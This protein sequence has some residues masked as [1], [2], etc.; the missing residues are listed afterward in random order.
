MIPAPGTTPPPF[1]RHAA[2]TAF[3]WWYLLL[4]FPCLF[5]VTMW[6]MFAL[7]IMI[8]KDPPKATSS[9]KP[10]ALDHLCESDTIEEC[11]ADEHGAWGFA[12][13]HPSS[14]AG[15]DPSITVAR[16]T[17]DGKVVSATFPVE[18]ESSGFEIRVLPDFD[19]DGVPE[20]FVFRGEQMSVPETGML[21]TFQQGAVTGYKDVKGVPVSEVSDVDGDGILDVSYRYNL[22]GG[23]DVGCGAPQPISYGPTFVAYGRADGTFQFY[24]PRTLA[25][26]RKLCPR[27][28]TA[29]DDDFFCARVWGF[30]TVDDLRRARIQCEKQAGGP[31]PNAVGCA[32]DPSR[33]GCTYFYVWAGLADQTILPRLWPPPPTERVTTAPP[34]S[35]EPTPDPQEPS[36][37]RC[38]VTV[39]VLG[40][41]GPTREEWEAT[42]GEER[43]FESHIPPTGDYH[44]SAS[45]EDSP[46]EPYD[47]VDAHRFP[48]A[49]REIAYKQVSNDSRP[50]PC[51]A[52]QG[53]TCSEASPCTKGL[54]PLG[55]AN[56]E[57]VVTD[58]ETTRVVARLTWS[59]DPAA[60]SRLGMK[61]KRGTLRVTGRGC[62]EKVAL[63][64]RP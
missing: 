53:C 26:M 30:G 36:H 64:S 4:P 18:R 54:A 55:P 16:I 20:V 38:P 58:R 39:T 12:T 8:A 15:A 61:V 2:G 60:K 10:E 42:A 19:K 49:N 45:C 37:A 32:E 63:A 11:I 33:D 21:L 29:A 57:L 56:R 43:N 7:L 22:D 40:S 23:Y 44:E 5:S 48:K 27:P 6:S 62:A 9:A 51:S 1:P 28:P 17:A 34:S 25:E 14:E 47:C 52:D 3:K 50:S 24:D 59:E 35:A 46:S 13:Q 31:D 41:T